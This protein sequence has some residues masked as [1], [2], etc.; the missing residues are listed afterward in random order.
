MKRVIKLITFLVVMSFCDAFSQEDPVRIVLLRHSVKANDG[1][2]DPPLSENGQKYA[3]KLAEFFSEMKFDAAF[4]TPYLRTENTIRPLVLANHLTIKH[5]KPLDVSEILKSVEQN[6][7]KNVIVAGH[8]N[9]IPFLVNNLVKGAGL[10]ELD[11]TDYGK[12]Y[13]VL[14]YK[15]IPQLNTYF[16]LNTEMFLN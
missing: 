6:S 11:E 12:V 3:E 8:S 5:Y 1:T 9:T 7:N 13:I 14:Y 16:I 15:N 2:G 10:K 4:S